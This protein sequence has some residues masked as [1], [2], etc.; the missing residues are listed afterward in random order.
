M[1]PVILAPKML[2]T[3][4]LTR[5]M[6]RVAKESPGNIEST[7]DES[8]QCQ[9]WTR[10]NWL[11]AS[12]HLRYLSEFDIVTEPEFCRPTLGSPWR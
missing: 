10:L 9:S 12:A 8:R 5:E 2:E 4:E 11:P 7:V 6:V 3:H 1:A